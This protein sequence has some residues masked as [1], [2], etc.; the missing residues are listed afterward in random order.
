MNIICWWIYLGALARR[1]IRCSSVGMTKI[2][3]VG[4]LNLQLV[5]H[6]SSR[7]LNLLQEA[8]YTRGL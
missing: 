8:M 6:S 7:Q 5:Y 4:T 3:S 1:Y 2:I